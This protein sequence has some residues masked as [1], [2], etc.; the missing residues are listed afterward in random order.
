MQKLFGIFVALAVGML[1]AQSPVDSI[2]KPN[3][4]VLDFSGDATVTT[5]QLKFISGKFSDELVGSGRFTVLDRSRIADILQEQGL[6]EN[7]VC[8][9]SDC[10]VRMGQLLGVDKL[11]SGSMVRFGDEY[12]F[13]VEYLDVS[14]GQVLYTVG[15][16]QAGALQSVYKQ[17]CVNGSQALIAKI[18]GEKT[19]KP[20]V[21]PVKPDTTPVVP[22]LLVPPPR[23]TSKSIIT[24]MPPQPKKSIMT[25]NRYVAAS[26]WGLSVSGFGAGYYYDHQ[27]SQDKNIYK[28]ADSTYWDAIYSDIQNDKRN[29][30]ASIGVTLGSALVGLVFWFLPVG[31][32]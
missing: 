6:Q 10:R 27:G 1:Y 11:V 23:D 2:G 18:F 7:G 14:S 4:A 32:N 9:G 15:F 16:E 28:N 3:I 29:R 25:W 12:A 5:D 31:G 26:C 17:A 20:L 21:T 8:T 30:N 24:P 22:P 19:D 13:R